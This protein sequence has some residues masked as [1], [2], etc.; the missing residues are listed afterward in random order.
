MMRCFIRLCGKVKYLGLL[1]LPG[2]FLKYRLFDILWL[3][4]LLGLVE[5][6]YN[7]PVFLQS[8]RQFWGMIYVPLYYGSH[9]PNKRNYRCKVQY[10]LPF[11]GTWTVVNGGVDKE[12]SHSWGIP[13]QRYAYDFLI[14]NDDGK[15]FM[16]DVTNPAAYHCYNREI[17]SPADGEIIEVGA[18]FPESPIL[19]NGRVDCSAHDLRG[20]YV[21]IRHGDHEYSLLAH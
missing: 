13:A 17:L 12:S 11:A 18:C 10:S 20:N 9:F 3:F 16:G 1:G 14:L 7:F 5:I 2:L 21:L 8:L 6:F 4:W 19:G 15:S